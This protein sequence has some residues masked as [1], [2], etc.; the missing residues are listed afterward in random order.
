[1]QLRPLILAIPIITASMLFSTSAQ[2]G[3]HNHSEFF[4]VVPDDVPL[5]EVTVAEVVNLYRRK[6]SEIQGFNVEPT[7]LPLDGYNR[8]AF[9][10]QILGYKSVLH[11][12]ERMS[13]LKWQNMA[14]PPLELDSLE[15]LKQKHQKSGIDVATY[16]Q[17]ESISNLPL[18]LKAIPIVN[19]IRH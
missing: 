18:G 15:Q 10:V 7:H 11:E 5:L 2:C 8:K 13:L 6:V 14:T 3:S 16:V 12:K 1:M 19:Q 4:L 9:T 17:K